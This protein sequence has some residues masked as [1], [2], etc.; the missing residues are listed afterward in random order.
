MR[1]ACAAEFLKL[2]GTLAAWMCLVSPALVVGVVVLQFGLMPL[3]D[4]GTPPTAAVWESYLK[5]VLGLWAFLMLPL[6]ITLQAALL[7]ALEH[8]N[9]QW[10]HLFALAVPRWHHYAAK[11]TAM[12][13]LV[14]GAHLV[15][16][17]LAPLG[18]WLVG[19]ARPALGIAGP[20]PWAFLL[21]RVGAILAASGLMMALQ[22]WIALR[23]SS[24]TVAVGA[25]MA[26][27]VAGFLIGQ[28]ERFG[29]F[30]PWSMPVATLFDDGERMQALSVA[31]AG[32]AL[33]AG[34]AALALLL[35]RDPE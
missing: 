33:L 32:G 2:R 23:W 30:Y 25:G 31:G 18:G 10:K 17:V 24:F 3:G 11:A 21:A 15:L 16:L 13:C 4:R 12:A 27:T 35:R 14:A 22:L 20:V 26:A 19:E 1:G 34:L 6:Y 28:S 9:R 29:K 7:A 5:G 8:G